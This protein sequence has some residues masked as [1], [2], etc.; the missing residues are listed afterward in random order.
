MKITDIL[1][2]NVAQEQI[3]F[4]NIDL[5]SDY[6]L[7]IDP[8]LISVADNAWCREVNNTIKNFFNKVTTL[9]IEGRKQEAIRLFQF[10]SEP[11]ETCLGLSKTGTTNGK[12]VGIDNAVEIIE[13]IIESGVIEDGLVRNIEDVIIFVDN[14]NKDKLSDMVTNLIR[15][16][17]LQYT[18]QQCEIW[19]VPTTKDESLPFWDV[20]IGDW[21]S[22]ITEHVYI[23]GRNILF[24]PK[25]IVSR[26]SIYSSDSYNR[27]FVLELDRAEH[28]QRRSSIVQLKKYKNGRE[29]F[30]CRKKDVDNYNSQ[31]VKQGD[32]YSK[33]DYFRKFTINHPGLFDSFIT[34]SG[35]RIKSLTNTE[36]EKFVGETSVNDLIDCLTSQLKNIDVGTKN[37]TRY[38]KF[39]RD[40]LELLFY[41]HLVNPTIE[42]KIHDGRKRIDIV[43]D[44]NSKDGFFYKVQEIN[45]IF[46]PYI[47]IECK[48]YSSDVANSELDQ[49]SGR[50]STYR[51]K[52]GILMARN[53]ENESR[54]IKR[55]QDTYKDGR[56]LIIPL[57]DKD[58]I[59]ML[60]YIKDD[61]ECG[62]DKYLENIKR[63]IVLS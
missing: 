21:N 15:G 45:K 4:V 1:G 33:K 24:V 13:G 19:G 54:L 31:R 52:F 56:G 53:V 39:I 32:F 49:L 5:E 16:H 29:E 10:M 51:G 12:G 17:L 58:V 57:L 47:Y 37:A 41:P 8:F 18:K 11:K 35:K 28:I 9:V 7:F 30:T 6:K 26:L 60:E 43:M 46:C 63:K 25:Y 14:V 27:G 38:H 62:I 20:N 22:I 36:L 23:E 61:D 48:N 44:N 2:L 55:C 42:E 34:S 3:D 59:K 50:F 40:I